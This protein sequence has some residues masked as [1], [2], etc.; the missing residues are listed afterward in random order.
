VTSARGLA[1]VARVDDRGL[2]TGA[3]LLAEAARLL[4]RAPAQEI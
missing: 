1:P 2:D 3:P 4:A